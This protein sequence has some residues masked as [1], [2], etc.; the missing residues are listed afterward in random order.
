MI[1]KSLLISFLFVIYHLSNYGNETKN[2]S[3]KYTGKVPKK[4]NSLFVRVEMYEQ[5]LIGAR[6]QCLQANDCDINQDFTQARYA[7]LNAIDMLMDHL[8]ALKKENAGA[9][10]VCEKVETT[11]IKNRLIELLQSIE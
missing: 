7:T 3:S 1:K 5:N 6:T 11:A 8:E 10:N 4:R 9:C 2:I